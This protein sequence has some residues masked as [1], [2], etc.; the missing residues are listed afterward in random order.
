MPARNI[1]TLGAP[2]LYK[3][4]EKVTKF[5]TPELHA[6]VKDINDTLDYHGDGYGLAAPQIGV[7][8]QVVVFGYDEPIPGAEFIPKTVLINPVLTPIGDEVDGQWESCYSLRDLVLYVERPV[9]LKY[10][11]FD[12]YGN[13]IERVVKGQHAKVVHHETDHLFGTLSILRAKNRKLTGH[14]ENLFPNY[15]KKRK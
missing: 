5:D 11:G 8:L 15:V 10:T 13:P 7:N 1:L 2:S 3:V 6:L 14:I 9:K 12:V 4:S